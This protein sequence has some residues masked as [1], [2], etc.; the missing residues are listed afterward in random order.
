[1]V[2]P[3]DSSLE[4][5]ERLEALATIFGIGL[6]RFDKCAKNPKFE[7]CVPAFRHEPDI[8]Y[9]NENLKHVEKKLFG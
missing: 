6:V 4:D 9:A 7:V 2:V 3:S 8:F 1:M 5:M